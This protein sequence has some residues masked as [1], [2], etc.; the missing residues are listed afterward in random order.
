MAI[1]ET[2]SGTPL[3][4]SE[5]VN[6]K[7][8]FTPYTESNAETGENP[9]QKSD[10]KQKRY[11]HKPIEEEPDIMCQEIEQLRISDPKQRDE[12][13]KWDITT[14]SRQSFKNDPIIKILDSKTSNRYLHWRF[15]SN[16]SHD[17]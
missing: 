6:P 1:P 7:K 14:K 10:M 3:E 5:K 4:N 9:N 12:S 2:S 16:Q 17:K 13:K 15:S 11:L 8:T